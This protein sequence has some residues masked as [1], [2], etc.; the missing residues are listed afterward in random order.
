MQ[1]HPARTGS[2]RAQLLDAAD[3]AVMRDGPSVS[4][5]AIA[6]E[7]GI[8]KPVLYRHFGD[9]GGLYKALAE[10]H[11][12]ALVARLRVALSGPGPARARA[13]AAID[14]YLAV[15]EARPQVYRFLM[16]RARVEDPRVR[17]QVAE[18]LRR[19]AEELAGGLARAAGGPAERARALAWAH[20]MVGMVQAAGDWWLEERPVD[21]ATLVGYLTDLLAGAPYGLAG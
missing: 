20:G 8:T 11:I 1:H 4:M 18:F 2:R 16:H 7:A 10:R 9:K 6:A 13:A 19:L 12:E 5:T 14:A 3:R 15:V 21:R 17:G